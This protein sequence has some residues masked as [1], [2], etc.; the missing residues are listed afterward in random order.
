M[1]NR[2]AYDKASLSNLITPNNIH[3]VWN[4]FRWLR[5]KASEEGENGV[6]P[7]REDVEKVILDV[8]PKLGQSFDG[9]KSKRHKRRLMDRCFWLQ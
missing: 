1:T 5:Q 6:Y 2:Y 8:L 9:V 4:A 7:R 3:R